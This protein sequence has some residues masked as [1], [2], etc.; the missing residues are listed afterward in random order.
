MPHA[1]RLLPAPCHATNRSADRLRQGAPGT[2]GAPPQQTH[3]GAALCVGLI[4]SCALSVAPPA[5]A[6]SY[7]LLLRHGESGDSEQ[8]DGIG[9]RL[10]ASLQGDWRGWQLS[11]RPEFELG[12]FHRSDAAA[13]PRDLN[14]AGALG[15]FRIADHTGRIRPFAEIGLGLAWFDHT[16]LGTRDFSTHAQFTESLSLGVGFGDRWLAGWQYVHYSNGDIKLPNDGIDLN[17]VFVGARF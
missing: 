17:Q 4:A 11:L 12:H 2:T 16:A 15:V 3:I 9:F 14:E 10:P 7:E 5:H 13:G 8:R 1:S 6:D